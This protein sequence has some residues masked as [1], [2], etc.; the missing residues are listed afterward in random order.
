MSPLIPVALAAAAA[1]GW[2]GYRFWRKC[3]RAVIAA[4]P[5]PD[6]WKAI[7]ERN[8]PLYARL[9][10][11]LR[12]RLH[13]R[14]RL[15][16]HDKRFQGFQ[17]VAIDD[18]IRVTV[19]GNACI[20]ILHRS[21]DEY[22][23]FNSIYIYPS[24]FLVE[25]ETWDGR[26]RNVARQARLGESWHRGPLVLAWDAA[27]HGTRDM[28][29][30]HNVILHEFAHKLDGADGTVDGA[31]SLAQRSHYVAWARVMTREYKRLRR[32]AQRR[33]RTVMDHYG[34]SEPQ[35]FFAVLVE[36]FF[37]KP[38][39]LK[40]RHPE[41]YAEMQRCFGLDPVEWHRPR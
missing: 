10:D 36:T 22:A 20:P 2:L 8:V 33:A 13:R 4:E 14:I 30:G 12:E 11:D 29:D 34:A 39:Q 38:R 23:G 32:R 31:P 28:R 24:T 6:T 21:V 19:A 40:K 9:S 17:G 7:L 41:L 3:R 27:L 18:V 26:V 15:F 16:L 25:H 37:E 35:E 5:L 1:L